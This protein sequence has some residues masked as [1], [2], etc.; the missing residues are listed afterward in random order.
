[1]KG[2]GTVVTGTLTSGRLRVDDSVELLPGREQARVRNVE[3][4]GESVNV[5]HAGQRTA[6]NLGGTPKTSLRRGMCLVQPKR[7]GT[8]MQFDAKVELL[9]SAK[10]LKHA[11]P[12]HVH[13]ATAETVGRAFI[14]GARGRNAAVA[15]GSEV[16][17][18]L[19]LSNPLVAVSRDRFILRQF[20]PMTTI[21]GGTVLHPQ[22]AR[23]RR[24]EDWRPLLQALDSG[25]PVHIL[26]LLCES[27]FY[28]ISG[29]ELASLT[30]TS[31]SQW[32]FAA[33]SA[34]SLHV[35]RNRPLWVCSAARVR[36]AEQRLLEALERFHNAN[37]LVAGASVQSIRSSEFGAAP[38]FFA[39]QLLHRLEARGLLVLDSELVRKADH[40]IRFQADEQEARDRLVAAFEEAG[41]RVPFLKE[42]LPTLPIDAARAQRILATLLRDGVLVRVSRELVFHIAAMDALARRLAKLRGQ[43][44][45]VGQ[46]KALANVTRKYA[47][48]LLEHCDRNKV[49]LRDGDL[50]RVL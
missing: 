18:Q 42:F 49:T 9:P 19:R 48:P 41:L 6:V 10:P 31:E 15:P 7:F 8:T 17:L 3:V 29:A 40:Q 37:P 30:G 33:R 45:T 39:D 43:T 11:A 38:D 20:S 13:L 34:K 44:I 35:M 23:H 5:A 26:Q 24:K 50:R 36:D 27:R 28:G 14:L 46:F 1:M 25:D 21:G 47:I 22:A 2:F 12:V 4:H 32:R 16:F